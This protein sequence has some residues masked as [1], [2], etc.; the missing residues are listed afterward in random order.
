MIPALIMAGG[1][2]LAS[3]L[4]GIFG[5]SATENTNK[6][7]LQ[8]TRETNEANKQLALQQNR[9]NLNMWK[10]NN[11]YNSPLNQMRRF[12]QAGMSGAAAAQAVSGVASQPVQSANLSNQVAPPPAQTPDYSFIGQNF[13]GIARELAALKK[14]NAEAKIAETQ[15]KFEPQVLLN[16]VQAEQAAWQLT[17]QELHERTST[18]SLRQQGIW[19]DNEGKK[20][21]NKNQEL[22]YKK[23]EIDIKILQQNFS[24]LKEMNAQEVIKIKQEIRNL[25]KE[26]E[27][28]DVQI[29]NAIKTGQQ[30][31]A[32]TA[33]IKQDTANK[34]AQNEQIKETTKSQRLENILTVGGYPDTYAQRVALMVRNGQMSFEEVEQ[35]YQQL[36]GI[37]Q[38]GYDKYG[39]AGY[40]SPFIRSVVDEGRNRESGKGL[41]TIGALDVIGSTI[42]DGIKKW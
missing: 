29:D 13:I 39:E 2:A 11:E 6:T 27:F 21:Y 36:Y 19:L 16:K 31:D 4:S 7:N 22:M 1:S 18:F 20:L 25:A 15:S 12:Q 3:A 14:E 35:D 8:A 26:E 9:F 33:N 23:V 42:K 38:Y 5:L 30:I 40:I 34:A 24:H 17:M 37:V 41:H 10:M 28:K 32:T